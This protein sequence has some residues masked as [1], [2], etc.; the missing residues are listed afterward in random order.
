MN[1]TRPSERTLWL[2]VAV[3]FGLMIAA[4]TAMFVIA[5]RHPVETV[6]LV[7]RPAAAPAK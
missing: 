5:A 3:V 7:H 1:E 6:P 2:T 4:W